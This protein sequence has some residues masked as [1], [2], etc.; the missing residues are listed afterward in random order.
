MAN[1]LLTDKNGYPR[2]SGN[3]R[4]RQGDTS[5]GIPRKCRCGAT[6]MIMTSETVKNP[7]RLFY[8]C[9]YGSKESKN[10]LFKWTDIAM[11]EEM[12]EVETKVEKIEMD[13]GAV[14]SMVEDCEKEMG[15][16]P[17]NTST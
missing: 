2:T 9:P 1:G 12:N 16:R 17:I 8:C 14:K 10:H 7:G 5:G 4:R 11:V 3:V 13:V 6:S 15:N